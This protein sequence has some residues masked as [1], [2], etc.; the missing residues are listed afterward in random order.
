MTSTNTHTHTPMSY[1]ESAIT[2]LSDAYGELYNVIANASKTHLIL[3]RMDDLSAQ[4]IN[5]AHV[6]KQAAAEVERLNQENE[7]LRAELG[8]ARNTPVPVNEPWIQKGLRNKWPVAP[9][10]PVEGKNEP[11]Y[12]I[13]CGGPVPDHAYHW[14]CEG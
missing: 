4:L 3:P 10:P 2:K 8:K 5:V 9:V 13:T 6:S 12:W 11:G 14:A 1:I 7:Y